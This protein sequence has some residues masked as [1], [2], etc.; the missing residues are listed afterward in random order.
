MTYLELLELLKL[1]TPEQLTQTVRVFDTDSNS[2]SDPLLEVWGISKLHVPNDDV[3]DVTLRAK[4]EPK[5]TP[6]T[7]IGFFPPFKI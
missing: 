3:G 6:K 7:T 5:L 2:D 4:Y 1:L